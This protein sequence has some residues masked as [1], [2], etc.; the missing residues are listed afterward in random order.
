MAKAKKKSKPKSKIG[1]VCSTV[2]QAELGE[3]S[4]VVYPTLEAARAGHPCTEFCKITKVRF[5]EAK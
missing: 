1:Y 2:Y 3:V 5:L 4:T